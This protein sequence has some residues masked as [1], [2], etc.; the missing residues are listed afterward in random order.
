MLES[1]SPL[2][3]FRFWPPLGGDSPSCSALAMAEAEL[4]GFRLE[5]RSAREQVATVQSKAMIGMCRSQ[6]TQLL[7]SALCVWSRAATREACRRRDEGVRAQ[8]STHAPVNN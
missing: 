6:A 7:S 4:G 8:A 1:P 5:M 3:R 2:S